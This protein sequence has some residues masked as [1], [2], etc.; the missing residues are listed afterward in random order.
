MMAAGLR[1]VTEWVVHRAEAAAPMRE[2]R[3]AAVT[4]ASIWAAAR[5]SA[6]ALAMRAP[7]WITAISRGLRGRVD[8]VT[9][10]AMI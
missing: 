4:G 10:G 9:C 1:Q 7:A 8:R 5:R 3:S 6:C 2:M